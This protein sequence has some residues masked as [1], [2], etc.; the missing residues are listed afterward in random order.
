MAREVD[1]GEAVAIATAV[2][3]RYY[4]VDNKMRE[5]LIAEGVVGVM[6]AVA[7]YREGVG[8]KFTTYAWKCARNEMAMYVRQEMKWRNLVDERVVDFEGAV[9]CDDD[10]IGSTT[11]HERSDML[12]ELLSEFKGERGREIAERLLS[13]ERQADVA[14]EFGVSR[15]RVWRI[16]SRIKAVANERFEYKDGELTRRS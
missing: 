15:Q 9:G 8:C 12:K 10:F 14:E 13:G 5:D 16:F 1:G 6:K 4:G 3:N 11:E 2:A 7:S